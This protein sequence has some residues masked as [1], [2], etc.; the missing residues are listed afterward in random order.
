M[1]LRQ[2]VAQT[3]CLDNRFRRKSADPIQPL[4]VPPKWLSKLTHAPDSAAFE[5]KHHSY[6][7]SKGNIPNPNPVTV[8]RIFWAQLL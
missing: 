3:Y 4:V 8:G 6:I 2:P 5:N 7:K 1:N